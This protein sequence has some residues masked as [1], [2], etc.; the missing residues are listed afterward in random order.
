MAGKNQ[1]TQGFMKTNVLVSKAGRSTYIEENHFLFISQ[2][3]NLIE[4]LN[5]FQK[6]FWHSIQTD[7]F[8]NDGQKSI[9]TRSYE[10]YWYLKQDGQLIL[11]RI[12]FSL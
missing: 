5:Q 8:Y 9:N 7:P 4:T 12:I 3:K 6:V 2:E 11:R 1:L 10:N